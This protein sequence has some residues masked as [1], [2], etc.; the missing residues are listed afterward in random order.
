MPSDDG[1]GSGVHVLVVGAGNAALCAALAAHERGARVTVLEKA[2]RDE[3]GGNTFFSGGGFRFPYD[4]IETIRELIPDLTDVEI[5]GIDVGAYPAATFRAD[6]STVTEGMA[7]SG[8]ADVLVGEAYPTMRWLGDQGVRWAFM[9]GRQANRVGGKLVFYGGLTLEAV[10]AGS[11]LSDHLFE[12]TERTGIEVRYGCKATSLVRQSGRTVGVVVE[13]DGEVEEMRADA[14]V[15]AAGG[16]EANA[17][18]RTR[19]LGPGWDLAK[20]RGSRFNTGDAIR[21]A[22]D[23]GAQSFGH[24]SGAHAV[25]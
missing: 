23:A 15:L 13:R 14:V 8:L 10:G 21:A 18:M 16:F 2:S 25:A 5:A 19:Y 4:G 12:S 9:T 24:L 3:R 17:E 6:I 11:G 20:V 1:T 22:L 7:D